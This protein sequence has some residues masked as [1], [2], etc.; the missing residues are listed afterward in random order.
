MNN[1]DNNLPN[2]A[3]N[4]S[5]YNSE[6][7][8]WTNKSYPKNHNEDVEIR[9]NQ[10]IIQP[11]RNDGRFNAELNVTIK[12]QN[13][14]ITILDNGPV[15]DHQNLTPEQFR[16]EA[17]LFLD[18]AL[19]NPDNKKYFEVARKVV[20]AGT[21]RLVDESHNVEVRGQKDKGIFKYKAT[22][23]NSKE[24]T[25]LKEASNLND[26]SKSRQ[27]Y[28]EQKVH[29]WKAIVALH[30]NTI[31]PGGEEFD[32]LRNIQKK[33]LEDTPLTKDEELK[34][35]LKYTVNSNGGWAISEG[36]DNNNPP[37]LDGQYKKIHLTEDKDFDPSKHLAKW[38]TKK[39]RMDDLKQKDT[40][41]TVEATTYCFEFNLAKAAN[42]EESENNLHPGGN[43]SPDDNNN[44]N[45]NIPSDKI[46]LYREKKNLTID[47]PSKSQGK[48]VGNNKQ[49][50]MPGSSSD[51]INI[52]K[53]TNEKLDQPVNYSKE[54][55]NLK[56]KQ[57]GKV[58][59]SNNKIN[60]SNSG[61]LNASQGNYTT[62]DQS[63]KK[64]HGKLSNNEN[65]LSSSSQS[66]NANDSNLNSK[67][68]KT[69]SGKVEASKTSKKEEYDGSSL[70]D[71]MN[72]LNAQLKKLLEATADENAKSNNNTPDT[73]YKVIPTTIQNKEEFIEAGKNLKEQL[74]DK[75]NILNSG[76]KNWL[77]GLIKGQQGN[78]TGDAKKEWLA[79]INE[80]NQLLK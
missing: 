23:S 24:G 78:F 60:Q 74:G 4:N 31:I 32:D 52:P 36:Y 21:T 37:T 12:Q 13:Y 28:I 53:Y 56:Q 38:E 71:A 35:L 10:A 49:E 70:E 45:L 80:V 27:T 1:M 58:N 72:R 46:G 40:D 5:L 73:T 17:I 25:K 42:F 63:W 57:H 43:F 15:E 41:E 8:T 67:N 44:N 48:L 55:L 18:K 2:I 19:N 77:N 75:F 62:E 47:D 79:L 54:E 51:G 7:I 34:Q 14:T 16:D 6:P 39:A 3:P 29:V 69:A 20:I 11:P 22:D 50:E 64:S 61:V 66:V 33:Y 30:N 76:K 68:L 9:V 65:D 26:F 59:S